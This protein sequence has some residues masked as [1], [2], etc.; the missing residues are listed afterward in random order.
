MGKTIHIH[1]L[2]AGF[3]ESKVKRDEGGKFS[4]SAAAAAHTKQ[5]KFH[6]NEANKAPPLSPAE[7]AHE[8]AMMA[9]TKAARLHTRAD[10]DP[11]HASRAHTA[12]K[13]AHAASGSIG[14]KQEAKPVRSPMAQ[15]NRNETAKQLKEDRGILRQPADPNRMKS[16]AREAAEANVGAAKERVAARTKSPDDELVSM[17]MKGGGK[18]TLHAIPKPPAGV[19][20]GPQPGKGPVDLDTQSRKDAPPN[21]SPRQAML[22]EMGSPRYADRPAA[23][24]HKLTDIKPIN[25][26]ETL[27]KL[28]KTTPEGQ[29]LRKGLAAEVKGDRDK[30]KQ[31]PPDESRKVQ[32]DHGDVFQ[33]KAYEWTSPHLDGVP[34]AA[35]SSYPEFTH[36]EV[37]G[38]HRGSTPVGSDFTPEFAKKGHAA[39]VLKQSDGTRHVVHTEGSNYAR[40]HAVVK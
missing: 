27:A 21:L 22:R 40:Y 34:S 29:A 30:A 28:N 36:K 10:V 38:T 3:D 2:D 13:E 33:R 20:G 25:V 15:A 18:E 6:H 32:Q 12:S 11:I 37:Y 26:Q 5:A 7:S 31:V 35:V 4:H 39:F 9:H 14:G 8:E 16:L 19:P 23:S 24:T 1:L 17:P